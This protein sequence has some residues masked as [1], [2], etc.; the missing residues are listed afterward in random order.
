MAKLPVL[1]ILSITLFAETIEADI[2]QPHQPHQMIP[3][4]KKQ[5]T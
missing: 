5:V 2:V 1:Q 4:E 3:H